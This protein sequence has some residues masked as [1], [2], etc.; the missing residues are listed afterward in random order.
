MWR[1]CFIEVVGEVDVYYDLVVCN[2]KQFE[3]LFELYKESWRREMQS[4]LKLRTYRQMKQFNS[5]M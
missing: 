5:L 4:K 2:L 3:K 1:I